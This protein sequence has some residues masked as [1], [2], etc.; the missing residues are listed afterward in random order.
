MLLVTRRWLTL[1]GFS[2]G[3][4]VLGALSLSMIGSAGL[5]SYFRMLQSFSVL[6][7]TGR[8]RTFHEIDLFSFFNSIFHDHV[9]LA[10]TVTSAICVV[11]F[12]ILVKQWSRLPA[13]GWALAIPWTTILNLYFLTYDATILIL[14]VLLTFEWLRNRRALRWLVLG[15][16]VTA[17]FDIARLSFQPFTFAIAAFGAYQLWVSKS[18]SAALS[19]EPA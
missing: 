4:V 2:L 13:R 7:L 17:F 3:A 5:P 11:V 19:V 16:F 6:K 10:I 8:R 18:Q 12:V 14:S 1:A 9:F 15:L